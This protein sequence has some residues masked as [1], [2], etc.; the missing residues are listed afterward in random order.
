LR[1]APYYGCTLQRP[2]TVGVE[3]PG[4]FELMNDFIKALGA[5]PVRF[6]AADECCGSYQILGHPEAAKHNA[7]H[8]LGTAKGAG[9][10]AIVLSCPL[11][12]FNLGK[13]QPAVIQAGMLQEPVPTFYFTQLLAI[14]LGLNPGTARFD[15]NEQAAVELLKS[16]DFPVEAAV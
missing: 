7:A 8:I 13:K 11:C 16:K 1:V 15:L 14:A 5:T 2:R 4:S 10:E 9:A 6:S 3:P 12:E